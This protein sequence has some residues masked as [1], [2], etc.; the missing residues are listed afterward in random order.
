MTG[1][2]SKAL[3]RQSSSIQCMEVSR[4]SCQSLPTRWSNS[5]ARSPSP[6]KRSK[7]QTRCSQAARLAQAILNQ[8]GYLEGALS[9]AHRMPTNAIPEISESQLQTSSGQTRCEGKQGLYQ[10]LIRPSNPS[11]SATSRPNQREERGK[12]IMMASMK[13]SGSSNRTSNP[14][15]SLGSKGCCTTI[16]PR[17][18]QD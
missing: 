4:N 5:L 6:R 11:S 1:S 9:P 14:P 8:H 7:S 3:E 17:N 16:Q 15:G 13:C 2:G 18:R 12:V 10:D